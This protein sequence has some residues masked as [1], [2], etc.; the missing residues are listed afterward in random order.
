M[1]SLACRCCIG[2][3]KGACKAR[4]KAT[5][6]GKRLVH[7]GCQHESE[8]STANDLRFAGPAYSM[9]AKNIVES[10]TSN[11]AR[12]ALHS[13]TTL[14]SANDMVLVSKRA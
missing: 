11:F 4:A 7:F 9:F 2:L 12:D 6:V 5:C 8:L 3:Q 1:K 14:N 13:I 10:F